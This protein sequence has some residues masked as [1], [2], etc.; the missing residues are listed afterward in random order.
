MVSIFHH[1]FGI[2]NK[3]SLQSK[4]QMSF[5]MCPVDKKKSIFLSIRE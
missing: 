5:Q 4:D 2:D 1:A 3:F